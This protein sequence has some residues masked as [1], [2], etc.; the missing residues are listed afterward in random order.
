[1]ALLLNVFIKSIFRCRQFL[2]NFIYELITG[3]IWALSQENLSDYTKY[4]QLQI[5]ARIL[6]LSLLVESRFN[7][8]L[9]KVN[10][11][12][13]DQTAQMRRLVCAFAVHMHQSQFFLKTS[14]CDSLMSI[15]T[16]HPSSVS[17]HRTKSTT[18][19][20]NYYPLHSTPANP[21]EGYS[22]YSKM[23][24]FNNQCSIPSFLAQMSLCGPLMS[25]FI[26][27]PLSV[28]QIWIR[29]QL[30]VGLTLAFT[31]MIFG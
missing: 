15:V 14:F 28:S 1:M 19:S 20:Y 24:A 3:N 26:M 10:N 13:A 29:S 23:V 25:L 21:S 30:L 27:W 31:G 22:N 5:I 17:Q 4:A 2:L 18:E 8:T 6:K 9:L 11:K 16:V 12:G 7:S